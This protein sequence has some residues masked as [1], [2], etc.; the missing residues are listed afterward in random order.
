[1]C[2]A[3]TGGY[4]FRL[5]PGSRVYELQDSKA[6]HKMLPCAEYG[7][8]APAEET[9]TFGVG[10]YFAQARSVDESFAQV[11]SGNANEEEDPWSQVHAWIEGASAAPEATVGETQYFDMSDAASS[12]GERRVSFDL[13]YVHRHLE[14]KFKR[15]LARV[16]R[17]KTAH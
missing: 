2:S 10:D 4:E 1:M 15:N 17:K 8:V 9:T 16:V 14:A 13:V 6:G 3:A 5:S 11:S 7:G 12:T